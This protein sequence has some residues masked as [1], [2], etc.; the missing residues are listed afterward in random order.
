MDLDTWIVISSTQVHD[1]HDIQ[2]LIQ[3]FRYLLS[4]IYNRYRKEKTTFRGTVEEGSVTEDKLGLG[5]KECLQ[6]D[7]DKGGKG[8][9]GTRNSL[10][11]S[12]C[13]K[14]TEYS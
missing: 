7:K 8:T 3:T 6:D 9:W 11:E 4:S 10:Y 12:T 14:R 2:S 5:L 1:A 13:Y